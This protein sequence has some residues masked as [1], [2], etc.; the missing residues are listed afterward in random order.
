MRRGP[1][2]STDFKKCRPLGIEA[3]QC[4]PLGVHG[5]HHNLGSEI[6]A[7][8]RE[9]QIGALRSLTSAFRGRQFGVGF[10]PLPRVALEALCSWR[11]CE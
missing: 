9:I 5:K 4:S 1:G 10:W 7:F 8:R 2:R 3:C 6:V 11:Y